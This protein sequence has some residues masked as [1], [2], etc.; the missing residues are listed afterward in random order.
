MARRLRVR[1]FYGKSWHFPKKKIV[2]KAALGAYIALS[3]IWFI[4]GV[5]VLLIFIFKPTKNP[6]EDF[7]I[8]VFFFSVGGLW[9][10][11]LKG[12]K[13][14]VYGDFFIY[15]NWFYMESKFELKK[16]QK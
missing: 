7:W 16:Y 6:E 1:K 3:G 9:V 8:S 14:E 10:I 13:L 12:L 4:L 15:R 5:C 2:A 11:C